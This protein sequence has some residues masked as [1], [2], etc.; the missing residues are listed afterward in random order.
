[1]ERSFNM[2]TGM[3]I[4]MIIAALLCFGAD[5]SAE[6]FG[7]N[8]SC[9]LCHSDKKK[10][11]SS[12]VHF[13]QG[14][15]CETCHG[16]DAE[17]MDE[18]AHAKAAGFK[19]RLGDQYPPFSKKQIVGLCSSC[20]SDV[21][22]MLQYG[23]SSD[24][25][26]LYRISRHGMA[27]FKNND[28]NVAVCTDCHGIHKI[29][30]ASDP[31]SLVS[32]GNLPSTCARCHSDE[33]LMKKYGLSSDAYADYANSVHGKALLE[34]S[35]MRAP[36]CAVCHGVHGALPPDINEIENVCGRCHEKTREFFKNSPHRNAM[37]NEGFSECVSCHG[38]HSIQRASLD[39][40]DTVC[41]ECHDP[42]SG[43]YRRGQ[44]IKA[45]VIDAL[46]IIADARSEAAEALKHGIDISKYDQDLQEAET[47]LVRAAPETHSL[48]IAKV[49]KLSRA[50]MALADDVKLELFHH[51]EELQER[52]LI[53]IA[54][55][56]FIL[57]IV[58][59]AVIKRY[60]ISRRLQDGK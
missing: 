58:P 26:E 8:Y 3:I 11:F 54:V 14:I 22:R 27:L 25:E 21:R 13:K 19:S 41:A 28:N 2:K 50:S 18:S 35:D 9:T 37:E 52:K 7:D 42:S 45:L 48:S 20:H 55:W 17:K 38:S 56:G 29:L 60:R 53:L 5:S 36:D 30:A 47:N 15:R 1:M 59:A 33:K 44:S 4:S 32:P 40:F 43:A 23:I 46:G 51:Q 24:Q 12:D 49:E 10:D 31:R 34:K 57:L 16:G 39:M 6:M